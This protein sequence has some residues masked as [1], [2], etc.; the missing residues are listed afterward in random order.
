MQT[1]QKIQNAARNIITF[2]D[3]Y[4]Q[5]KQGKQNEQP[6]SKSKPSLTAIASSLKYIKYQIQNNNTSKSVIQ[7]P[8]LLKSLTTLV[9]FRLD[10]HLREEIDRQILE[11]RHQSRECLRFIQ[12]YG[13][14]QVQTE[15]VNNEYGRVISFSYST[16]GGKGE[17]RDYEIYNGLDFILQFLRDLHEGRN[18]QP[19][20]QPLP[21]LAR[22]TEEQIEE[23]GALEEIDA[24][25]INKG[26]NGDIKIW[27]NE[28][29]V[30]QLNRFIYRH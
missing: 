19:S 14:E 13:D 28:A 25:M 22:R 30:M 8:N 5:G 6:E 12:V 23:E 2:T 7:I 18:Y 29:K 10:T 15:L 24:Q 27:T 3:S 11:V 1:E 17:E 26:K 4:T 9:T 21:L 20:F 16:S